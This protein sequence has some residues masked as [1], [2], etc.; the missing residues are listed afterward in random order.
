VRV[1]RGFGRIEIIADAHPALLLGWAGVDGD[2]GIGALVRAQVGDHADQKTFVRVLV[3]QLTPIRAAETQ[4]RRRSQHG[5]QK[6]V[7]NPGIFF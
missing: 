7:V 4:K 1:E 5:D 3:L 2:G 6:Q